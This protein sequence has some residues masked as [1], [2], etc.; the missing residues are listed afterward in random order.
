MESYKTKLES[1]ET[2]LKSCRSI[3]LIVVLSLIA[4]ILVL[5]FFTPYASIGVQ[6]E[7]YRTHFASGESGKKQVSQI[8]RD[9]FGYDITSVPNSI[10]YVRLSPGGNN[11]RIVYYKVD[12][13]RLISA[14]YLIGSALTN[15]SVM[16]DYGFNL[17]NHSAMAIGHGNGMSIYAPL[18]GII[19][20]KP[21]S[22][23][24]LFR[25]LRHQA[26]G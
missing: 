24:I 12:H 11:A 7:N 19:G 13:G 2:K 21:F 23:E 16:G 17:P 20:S 14:G 26:G 6:N 3:R 9:A 4:F 15:S 18:T 22:G 25:T 10:L 1:C 5:S 8:Y